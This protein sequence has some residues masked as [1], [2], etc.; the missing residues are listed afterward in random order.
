MRQPP[1]YED[2]SLP[3][4]VCKSDQALYGLKQAPHAWY[5]Q[6]SA[7]LVDLGF[8]SSKADTSLFY[9]NEKGVKVF[10]FIYVD[11]IIVVNSTQEAT[12]GL[13]NNLKQEF[14]LKDLGELHYFLGIEVNKV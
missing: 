5:A 9:F 13:L 11:D 14:A 6:L 7:K 8:V 2:K 4:F 3:N 12:A 1:G 10:V